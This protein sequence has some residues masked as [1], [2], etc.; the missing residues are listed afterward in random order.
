MLA[1]GTVGEIYRRFRDS[2]FL[3][4]IIDAASISQTEVILSRLHGT[5]Y[6]KT[7]ILFLSAAKRI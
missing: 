1:L 2:H 5:K 6:Q 3:R 7:F 4:Y